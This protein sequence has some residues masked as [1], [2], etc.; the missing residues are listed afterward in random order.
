MFDERSVTMIDVAL[1]G[2]LEETVQHEMLKA[3]G[4]ALPKPEFQGLSC[5]P[6]LVLKKVR[7]MEVREGSQSL[8]LN[9]RKCEQSRSLLVAITLSLCRSPG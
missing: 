3:R 9:S 6:K 5:A 2:G 7:T 8:W 4:T 1:N